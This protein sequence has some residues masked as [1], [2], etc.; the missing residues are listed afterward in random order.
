MLRRKITA[1]LLLLTMIFSTFAASM[2]VY[3]EN[4]GYQEYQEDVNGT[5]EQGDYSKAVALL[6][7]LGIVTDIPVDEKISRG[8]FASYMIQ[9]MNL[10]VTLDNINSSEIFTDVP[11]T[12]PNAS[13][14]LAAYDLGLMNGTGDGLFE[15]DE[16]ITCEQALKVVVCMLGYGIT[17]HDNPM[18]GY[19]ETATK[20]K[21]NANINASYTDPITG[22]VMAQ[23]LYNA[24]D[25]KMLKLT[26]SGMIHEYSDADGDTLLAKHDIVKI[27]DILNATSVTTLSNVSTLRSSQ[28]QIGNTICEVGTTNAVEYL[29]YNVTAYAHFDEDVDKVPTIIDISPVANKNE[30]IILDDSNWVG[31]TL[32]SDLSKTISY[33]IEGRAY[34]ATVASD[35]DTIY[36]GVA[37]VD[38]NA[39]AYKP[40]NAEIVLIDNDMNGEYDVMIVKEFDTLVVENISGSSYTVTGTLIGAELDDKGNPLDKDASFALNPNSDEY[41]VRLTKNGEVVSFDTIKTNNVLSILAAEDRNGKIHY[42]IIISDL[43]IVGS[44]EEVMEEGDS[45]TL[46]IS[47]TEYKVIPAEK[48]AFKAG[49]SGTFYLDF[50]SKV[51][52]Y[53]VKAAGGSAY[54]YVLGV[55]E[56]KGISGTAKLRVL[57]TNGKISEYE[58]KETITLS[59]RTEKLPRRITASEIL[60]NTEILKQIEYQV[61]QYKTNADSNITEIVTAENW[62]QDYEKG[63]QRPEIGIPNWRKG[64]IKPA[65]D[66]YP[67]L[68]NRNYSSDAP[69]FFIRGGDDEGKEDVILIDSECLVFYVPQDTTQTDEFRFEVRR[70]GA[71]KRISTPYPMEIFNV[72][73][74]TGKT[75][76]ALIRYSDVAADVANAEAYI[77]ESVSKAMK[78]DDQVY[79]VSAWSGG[80]NVEFLVDPNIMENRSSL[81]PAQLGRGDIVQFTT[82]SEGEINYIGNP[83]LDFDQ[84]AT[85]KYSPGEYCADNGSFTYGRVKRVEGE[86]V[87]VDTNYKEHDTTRYFG[88]RGLSMPVY[89][90]AA[91]KDGLFYLGGVGD[92]EVGDW[93]LI[94]AGQAWVTAVMVLKGVE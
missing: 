89:D 50:R 81:K 16:V 14:I 76:L 45:T 13:A 92:I 80:G 84:K 90:A 36:N 41:S 61:I 94:R 17:G 29:G 21:L 78:G 22:G 63:L 39:A 62:A 47:L 5:T 93:V 74:R 3:A 38:F 26:S 7:K 77:V 88:T 73:P 11:A 83:I 67:Y 79:K 91:G 25:V 8:A 64:E 33:N 58:T 18:M 86:V 35:G 9:A 68:V 43:K 20:F 82:N 34:K 15:P 49:E 71:L 12:H 30:V 53:S 55:M 10:G 69:S 24:L 2:V 75:T 52:S 70:P 72:D 46:I 37:N 1:Y 32:N 6:Q 57:D 31:A 60:S 48:N 87:A 51:A 44:I 23:I 42:D 19:L 28:V 56:T 40:R 54:G 66:E 27:K 65:S 4:S 59:D 85:V